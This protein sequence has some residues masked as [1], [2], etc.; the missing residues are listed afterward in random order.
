MVYRAPL[1]RKAWGVN[2]TPGPDTQALGKLDALGRGR[3]EWEE[4]GAVLGTS[5]DLDEVPGACGWL[6]RWI[7]SVL[8]GLPRKVKPLFWPQLR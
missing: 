6:V 3:R 5:L 8:G 1:F 4:G 2:Q 7:R